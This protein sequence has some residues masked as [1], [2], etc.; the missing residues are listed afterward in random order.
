[1]ST[2]PVPDEKGDIQQMPG[3]VV[4]E[5]EYSHNGRYLAVA[6][7]Y[8]VDLYDTET[9][10]IARRFDEGEASV[11][12]VAF[13]P[14]DGRL[15]AALND[16]TIRI[17]DVEEGGLVAAL[18]G[19]QGS[20]TSVH[21]SPDDRRLVSGSMDRTIRIWDTESGR[22]SKMVQARAHVYSA[23][24]NPSGDRIVSA[25]HCAVRVW[26]ANTGAELTKPKGQTEDVASCVAFSP[27]GTLIVARARP[28]I[29]GVWDSRTGE[30]V[31]ALKYNDPRA[32]AFSPDGRYMALTGVSDA[33]LRV[34]D[35]KLWVERVSKGAGVT[36]LSFRPDGGHLAAPTGNGAV[37]IYDVGSLSEL[38]KLDGYSTPV[39]ALDIG[40][41]GERLIAGSLSGRIDH[42]EVGTGKPLWP[43]GDNFGGYSVTRVSFDREARLIAAPEGVIW[44]LTTRTRRQT[45]SHARCMCLSPDGRFLA[46]AYDSGTQLLD[47]A[48]NK[49]LRTLAA[50][51]VRIII[52]SPN[53]Q[54]LS[55]ADARGA[56]RTYDTSTWQLLWESSESGEAMLALAFTPKG[57]RVATA[58]F[59]DKIR[60]W[61]TETGKE[62]SFKVSESPT[63]SLAF[64]PDGRRVATA[65]YDGIVRIRDSHTGAEAG[66]FLGS[67]RRH[68]GERAEGVAFDP[69]GRYLASVGDDG[70]VC[71]WRPVVGS[72]SAGAPRE[73]ALPHAAPAGKMSRGKAAAEVKRLA[74]S[75]AETFADPIDGSQM[76]LIP[77]GEFTMG[78]E[79]R[80]SDNNPSHQV[81]LDAFYISKH[82]I[83]NRQWKAFIEEQPAWRKGAVPS[84]YAH[85]WY[86][87]RW[88]DGSYPEGEADRPVANV[89]W[90]AANAY[91]KWA[92]GR[93]PTEAEWEK[94]A[95]G[96]DGRIYPWGKGWDHSKCNSVSRWAGK[97]IPVG[98]FAKWYDGGGKR[99]AV[100][101]MAV[102]SFPAGA[103]PYGVLDLAG[104]VREWTLSIFKAYPYVATDGREDT[105][106]TNLR[107]VARGGCFDATGYHCRAV[108]RGNPEPIACCDQVGFRLTVPATAGTHGEP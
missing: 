81:H 28:G 3:G 58:G 108:V 21:F 75:G 74:A 104:N 22:E 103:S 23:V 72:H 20:V 97:D 14:D 16:T 34:W 33:T 62:L 60:S 56:V 1:M 64:S 88:K 45:D 84:E 82:E 91:C 43:S 24:F 51:H 49:P 107:R 101:S 17:W 106:E 42:W 67:P 68:R 99:V 71:L 7:S 26:D 57:D 83:T 53:G 44:D 25:S 52:Y 5:V 66:N 54:H 19:H 78:V 13:S 96:T 36:S 48:A 35:A 65:H 40:P 69:Q 9:W 70:S 92:G 2:V 73:Q 63:M 37:R 4:S 50:Q 102:G 93:L 32:I 29:T 90:F 18:T 39:L 30:Q 59:G 86:M 41:Q 89:N 95:R 38:R 47:I 87:L 15:A 94:A 12:S 8:G 79:G 46:S 80:G 98:A 27:D 31:K 76:I 55:C 6:H 11:K 100:A 85:A 77:A 61:D 10:K 105:S